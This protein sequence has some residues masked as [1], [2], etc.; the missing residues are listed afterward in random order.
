MTERC[1][2]SFVLVDMNAT[3]ET[4]ECTKCHVQE[5]RRR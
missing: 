5:I 2:H 1:D 3:Y 4:Y